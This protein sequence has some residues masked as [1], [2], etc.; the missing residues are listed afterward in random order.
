MSYADIE[1]RRAYHRAYTKKWRLENPEKAKASY[2]A[3]EERMKNYTPEQRKVK[4][5]RKRIRNKVRAYLVL[6]GKC[7][8][9]GETDF[10]LLT[11]NHKNGDG[12]IDR[13][14]HKNNP[15]ATLYK[16]IRRLER[17]DLELLCWNC[18]A[19]FEWERE[20]HWF[21]KEHK[22]VLKKELIDHR[23]KQDWFDEIP[24]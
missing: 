11:L 4:N 9:C 24:D 19:L 5:L 8:L 7:R 21:L 20:G 15:N 2:E 23:V 22:G 13:A 14:K 6:G 3:F 12:N 16:Q 17:T 10:R 1:K 18:Q